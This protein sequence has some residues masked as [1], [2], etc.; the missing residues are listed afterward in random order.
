MAAEAQSHTQL[1]HTLAVALFLFLAAWRRDP[2]PRPSREARQAAADGLSR[3]LLVAFL[4]VGGALLLRLPLLVFIGAGFA[5]A[6]WLRLLTGRPRLADAA[7]A[8]TACLFLAALVVGQTD[9]PLRLLA[10]QICLETL[11][12]LG[13]EPALALRAGGGLPPAILLHTGG[14][15]YEVAAECNGFGLATGSLV[16]AVFLS[17]F[18]RVGLLRALLLA[19]AAVLSA[20]L[21]NAARITAICVVAPHFPGAYHQVHEIIG[22]AIFWAGLFAVYKLCRLARPGAA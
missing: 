9:W 5:P 3:S 16:T 12:A 11:R 13:F 18:W 1:S 4:C 21:F 2:A 19:P 17:V 10:G 22:A 6:G 7:G 20:V 15:V 8:V 14:R